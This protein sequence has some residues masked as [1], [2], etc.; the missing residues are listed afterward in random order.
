MGTLLRERLV[1]VLALIAVSGAGP[2]AL[3]HFLIDATIRSPSVVHFLF[4]GVLIG[5]LAY[6]RRQ[7]PR[8][9][10]REAG[11]LTRRIRCIALLRRAPRR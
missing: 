11:G 9:R 10:E 1:S 7:D 8:L 6:L 5:I 2:A 4:A 3:V